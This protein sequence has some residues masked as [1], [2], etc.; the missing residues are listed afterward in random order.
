[1]PHEK[2]RSLRARMITPSTLVGDVN[3]LRTT[4]AASAS[5]TIGTADDLE[6]ARAHTDQAIDRLIRRRRRT[7]VSPSPGA[8]LDPASAAGPQRSLAQ[9]RTMMSAFR[10]GSERGL[11]EPSS[12]TDTAPGATS[13]PD[14]RAHD[15]PHQKT[16]G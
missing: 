10:S 9:I 1:M 14:Q 13:T 8:G 7:S 2:R 15:Q 3:A 5:P 4:V 6:T 11:A 16:K 12:D